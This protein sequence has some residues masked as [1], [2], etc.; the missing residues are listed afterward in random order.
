MTLERLPPELLTLI[1]QEVDSPVSLL[2]FISASPQCLKIF[3]QYSEL[4]LSTIIR[5]TVPAPTL[6]HLI[7]GVNVPTGKDTT[8]ENRTF[9]LDSYL[10]SPSIEFPTQKE[11]II[12]MCRLWTQV[13]HFERRYFCAAMAEL[14]FSYYQYSA[15]NTSTPS[16]VPS[17]RERCDDD[18]VQQS[19]EAH[20]PS[21]SERIR[22]QRAFLRFDIY[23]QL[24]PLRPPWE[25]CSNVSSNEQFTLILSRLKP[26]EVEEITCV[27][28]YLTVLAGTYVDYLQ[29]Q[30]VRAV[31]SRP[32]AVY[33]E[34]PS[35][36]SRSH[37]ET[38]NI[39]GVKLRSFDHID[40]G[41]P[42]FFYGKEHRNHAD[43]EANE[44][45]ARGLNY[46]FRLDT[47]NEHARKKVLLEDGPWIRDFLPGALECA[48]GYGPESLQPETARNEDSSTA[49][50]GCYQYKVPKDEEVYLRINEMYLKNCGVRE[51]GYVFWDSDRIELSAVQSR[52]EKEVQ[53]SWAEANR[54]FNRSQKPSAEERL[55]GVLLQSEDIKQVAM[56]YGH[57][58]EDEEDSFSDI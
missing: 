33:I 28:Q 46:M 27:N 56:E 35:T 23:C 39:N 12:S 41:G 19:P 32:G 1:L 42:F 34:P 24:F 11:Q 15:L 25:G 10:D 21:P 47:S 58:D 57:L 6:P 49:N 13:S 31:L 4:I 53:L 36:S 37:P 3:S 44:L 45:A 48:P 52:L 5:K 55:S 38:Q 20:T 8:N 54:R 51:L 2:R 43:A 40:V 17:K 29:D 18:S 7:A 14:G 26:W 30:F 9:F 22:L 16:L 50:V